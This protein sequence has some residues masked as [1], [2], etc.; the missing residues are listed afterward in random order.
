MNEYMTVKEASMKWGISERQVQVLCRSGKIDGVS[1]LGRNWLIPIDAEKPVDK[2]ITSG[3][4][5]NWRKKNENIE[6]S[7]VW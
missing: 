3:E 5:K 6:E 4:Y 2:R 1:K 7:D